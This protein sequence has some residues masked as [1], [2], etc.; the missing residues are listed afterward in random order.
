MNAKNYAATRRYEY[1]PELSIRVGSTDLCRGISP[2]KSKT[3][4]ATVEEISRLRQQMVVNILAIGECLNELRA[5]LG[6]ERFAHFMRA[7]LPTIGISRAT[8]YRWMNLADKLTLV[9][10][11]SFVRRHL[12]TLTD[13]RGILAKPTKHGN[14]DSSIVALTPAAQVALAA[15]P[16]APKEQQGRI[17]CEH[18]VTQFIK[19]IGK[20]RSEARTPGRDRTKHQQAI[21]L[22]YKRF[23]ACYGLQAAEDLCGELDKVL[24]ELAE[25]RA[26]HKALP[27]LMLPQQ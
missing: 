2:A 4:I 13:G 1:G 19:T 10:P 11:N 17:E 27:A 14:G 15:L 12:L 24:N 18:W 9:F 6:S 23:V 16:P 22:S 21:I 26:H 20:V 3:V 7:V 5:S 8:G 25:G